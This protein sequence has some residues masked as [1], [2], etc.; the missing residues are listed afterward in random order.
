MEGYQWLRAGEAVVVDDFG[1]GWAF[2]LQFGPC[3]DQA[4]MLYWVVGLSHVGWFFYTLSRVHTVGPSSQA[5]A[6]VWSGVGSPASY[7][8]PSRK[9][10][11]ELS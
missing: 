10:E 6:A 11:A 2:A 3:C 9:T 7:K 4:I 5:S 1:G 8:V